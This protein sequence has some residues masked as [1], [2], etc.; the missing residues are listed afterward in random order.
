MTSKPG[1]QHRLVMPPWQTFRVSYNRNVTAF[2]EWE[3]SSFCAADDIAARIKSIE[4]PYSSFPYDNEGWITG[5][6]YAASA[7]D[8]R[9]C[10]PQAGAR[11]DEDI[12]LHDFAEKM[13]LGPCP[14]ALVPQVVDK[15]L[16][17][18]DMFGLRTSEALIYVEAGDGESSP[19]ALW[20]YRHAPRPFF[21]HP[22]HGIYL[23]Q[24]KGEIRLERINAPLASLRDIDAQT[25]VEYENLPQAW[26]ATP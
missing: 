23:S 19:Y 18:C 9:C 21:D 7:R 8:L 4:Q 11:L 10:F 15:L 17:G 2:R 24:G 13:G 22:C 25:P 16:A 20:A 6:L 14:W 5:K 12:T 1:D 3:V 26:L